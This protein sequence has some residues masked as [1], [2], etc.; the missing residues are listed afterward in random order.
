MDDEFLDIQVRP[1]EEIAARMLILSALTRRSVI[2]ALSAEEEVDEEEDPDELFFD[3]T[4]FL[5]ESGAA[6]WLTVDEQRIIATPPGELPDRIADSLIEN[7]P[8]LEALVSATLHSSGDTAELSL[9]TTTVAS[10]VETIS[11]PDDESAASLRESAELWHWRA[12]TEFG[13]RHTTGQ[14]RRSLLTLV[15]ETAT[16]AASAGLVALTPDGDFDAGGRS[17]RELD[18]VELTVLAINART[19]LKALNWLCG[20]GDSWDDVP[21]DV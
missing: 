18:D 12:E 19:R 7:A 21:L 3:L 17:L 16:E 13:I 2:E 11:A 10:L 1:A 4:V 6:R 8:A 9:D 5:A 20:F 14:E 15:R